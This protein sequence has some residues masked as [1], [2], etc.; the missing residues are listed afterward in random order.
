MRMD[1]LCVRLSQQVLSARVGLLTL[2]EQPDWNGA[3]IAMTYFVGTLM[4][5]PFSQAKSTT[6]LAD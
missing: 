5:Y 6:N 2:N 4:P 1:G 3:R